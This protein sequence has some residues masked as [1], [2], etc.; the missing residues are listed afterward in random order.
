MVIHVP[1]DNKQ[2]VGNGDGGSSEVM[3]LMPQ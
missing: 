2:K 1:E 3:G